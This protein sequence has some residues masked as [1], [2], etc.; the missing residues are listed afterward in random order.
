MCSKGVI[1]SL[2]AANANITLHE[3]LRASRNLGRHLIAAR[4]RARWVTFSCLKR[5]TACIGLWLNLN[6]SLNLLRAELRL[7]GACTG[8]ADSGIV[9]PMKYWEIIA[10]KLSPA[11]WS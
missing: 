2:A 8:L 1:G 10:E 4:A 9:P 7:F 11:D 6:D 5:Q 3:L